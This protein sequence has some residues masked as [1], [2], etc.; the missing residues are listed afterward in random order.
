MQRA[1]HGVESRH[2]TPVGRL[3]LRDVK[4]CPTGQSSLRKDGREAPFIGR[5]FC[6]FNGKMNLV[7]M[8]MGLAAGTSRIDHDTSRFAQ[9]RRD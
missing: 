8:A 1:A 9:G 4:P 2:S 6:N 5:V 3:C 7:R